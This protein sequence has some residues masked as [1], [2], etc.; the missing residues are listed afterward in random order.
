MTRTGPIIPVQFPH[1]AN[2][3]SA[4]YSAWVN[5]LGEPLRGPTLTAVYRNSTSIRYCGR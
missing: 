3:P 2:H 1:M 4:A 5:H